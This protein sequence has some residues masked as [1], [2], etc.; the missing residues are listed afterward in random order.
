MVA[1][2][3]T[4]LS[5]SPF[6]TL[7]K[8]NTDI[9]YFTRLFPCLTI[10]QYLRRSFRVISHGHYNLLLFLSTLNTFRVLRK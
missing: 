3:R 2:E 5:K 7:T 9:Q 8:N 1:V 4:D 6:L 10:S